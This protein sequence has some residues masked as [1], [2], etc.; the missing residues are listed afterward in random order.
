MTKDMNGNELWQEFIHTI[1]RLRDENGCPWDREQTH[2]SLKRYLIEESYEVIDA[3]DSGSDDKLCDELGDVLLQV[4]LHAQIAAED[5][6]FAIDDVVRNVNQKMIRRHP[7]VFGDDEITTSREVLGRWESIKAQE[8]D[9]GEQRRIMSVNRNLPA[10]MLAQK[11]QE[12]A[13]RVGFDWPDI[14]GPWDKLS[15]EIGELKEAANREQKSEELG[16]CIFALVNIARFMD[17]D[18]EDSLRHCV[19]KVIARFNFMEDEIEKQGRKFTD[20]DLEK[21]DKLW[22]EAK[23]Q[24]G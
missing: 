21:L 19:E 16:D 12:K 4:V 8:K 20:F 17:L 9:A 1:A 18:A 15:E 23:E 10:L 13:A 3:I 5:G 7:H 24:R 14:Q 6:R 11:V 22:D 2:E